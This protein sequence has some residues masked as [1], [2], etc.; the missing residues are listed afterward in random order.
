MILLDF[1]GL[2]EDSLFLNASTFLAN[3][4]MIDLLREKLCY[5]WQFNIGS[6]LFKTT[7]FS[8]LHFYKCLVVN[9]ASTQPKN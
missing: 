3:L 2:I 1:L 4:H 8:K 7:I 9:K 5:N 6:V